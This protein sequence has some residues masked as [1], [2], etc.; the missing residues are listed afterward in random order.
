MNISKA[1]TLGAALVVLTPTASVSAQEGPGLEA[2][3]LL[4]TVVPGSRV[5][6]L[7]RSTADV[8]CEYNN[9]GTIEKY[10]GETGI[11]LG[12]DLSFKDNER[13]AWTV[14][15]ASGQIKPGAYALAGKYI[16]GKADATAGVGVGAAALVGGMESSFT[17]QPLSLTTQTG[18]GVSGGLGFL[19]LE[20]DTAN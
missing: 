20:A 8:S 1:L 12:L 2:G 17:L 11:A 16:G 15:A 18:L 9:N 4:C 3:V 6:L 19:Y 14:V 7:V 10:K 5:N 13:M